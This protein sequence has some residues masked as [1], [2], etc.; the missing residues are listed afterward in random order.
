M[1]RT[2]DTFVALYDR[3]RRAFR[4][5]ADLFI[6]VHHNATGVGGNPREARHTVTYASNEAGLA[7]A[8]A[9][10]RQIAQAVVT[11]R[12]DGA[13]LKSLAVCRNPAVPSCLVEV[14]FMNL[15]EGEEESL[16]PVRRRN[17]SRAIVMG[18]LDWLAE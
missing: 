6:S 16:D 3:P 5:R 15:P 11:V 2:N 12:N 18:V 7:L 4:E 13:K 17:V 14:D 10:Q 9:I 1:T 8:S